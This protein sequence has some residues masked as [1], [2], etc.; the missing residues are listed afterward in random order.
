MKM[1]KFNLGDEVESM[2]SG[3]KGIVV[4]RVQY[5]SGCLQYSVVARVQDDGK[6]PTMWIDEPH[7]KITEAGKV[8]VNLDP[9]APGGPHDSPTR[10]TP[11]QR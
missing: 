5:L 4:G 9:D 8:K 2:V 10:T 6:T 1:F 3:F 7:L 11:P